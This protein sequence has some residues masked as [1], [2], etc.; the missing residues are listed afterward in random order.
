MKTANLIGILGWVTIISFTIA[1]LNFVMKYIN[2][3]YI[4][5]LGKDKKQIVDMYRKIMKIVVKNHKLAGTIAVVSV[6][7]HFIIAFSANRIK[8]TGII[9]AAIMASIFALG[10]YGAYINKTRKGIWL[11]IH[12]LLAFALVVAILVHII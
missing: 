9:A 10:I 11:K 6:L 4:N 12:R 7:A 5:K 8:I 2:K 3:K 1:I